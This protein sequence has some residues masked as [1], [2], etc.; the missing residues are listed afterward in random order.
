MIIIL[1]VFIGELN[2]KSKL[3]RILKYYKINKNFKLVNI[4]LIL[5]KDNLYFYSTFYN[6]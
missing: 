5:F 6:A 3:G 2:Y 4:S 1:S